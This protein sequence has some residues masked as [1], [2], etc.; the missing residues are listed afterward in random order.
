MSSGIRPMKIRKASAGSGKT[1]L[2]VQNYISLLLKQKKNNKPFPHR[3]ILAVTFTN[4]ATKEMKTRI[5]K[6]LFILSDPQKKS[7]HR[8]KLCK[9]LGYDADSLAEESKQLLLGILNDYSSFHISTIDK[10]F[11]KILRSFT[12]E[13]N[14][15]SDYSIELDTTKVLKEAI[16]TMLMKVDENKNLFDWLFLF[17]QEKIDNDKSWDIENDILKL[18]KNLFR[19]DVKAFNIPEQQSAE[20]FQKTLKDI[21][22]KFES[23]AKEIADKAKSIIENHNLEPS[24]FSGGATRSFYN[25]FSKVYKKD[26][27]CKKTFIEAKDNVDKWY[28]QT[29]KRK[30]DIK[31]VFKE[32][33]VCVTDLFNLINVTSDNFIR[34]NSAKQVLNKIYELGILSDVTKEIKNYLTEEGVLLLPDMNEFLS[35]IIANSDTPF[36]YEKTG[37]SI[38]H[39]MLDEFQ[40]TSELQW[41]NFLPLIQESLAS[42]NENLIVGDVKQS[43]YRW[44]NSDWDL[45]NSKIMNDLQPNVIDADSSELTTNWRSFKNIV[46]FNN[47]FFQFA[48]ETAKDTFLG[49]NQGICQEYSDKIEKA[50]EVLVQEVGKK[51]KEE[52][53]VELAFIEKIKEEKFT[54]SA[55]VLLAKRI[56]ELQDRGYALKDIVV[57]VRKRAEIRLIADFLSK[58]EKKKNYRYD[59]LSEEALL[60]AKSDSVQFLISAM[61]YLAS[62]DDKMCK[63][64]FFFNYF[65]F[66]KNFELG[67]AINEALNEENDCKNPIFNK[68][69][70]FQNKGSLYEQVEFLIRYF[71]FLPER[72]EEVIYVQTFQDIVFDFIKKN[73]ADLI[74]F[75][76]YWEEK[77][78]TFYLPSSEDSQDAIRIITIH[79][80]KGLEFD[81]VILPFCNWDLEPKSSGK[82]DSL[83]WLNTEN[84]AV[85]FNSYPIVPLVYKKDLTNTI[86]AKQY[87]EEM[88]QCYVDTLN[89]TYVA[90]T[91]AKKELYVFI[92]N[93]SSST[94]DSTIKSTIPSFLRKYAEDKIDL[95]E[96]KKSEE[97]ESFPYEIFRKGIFEQISDTKT[98]D[99]EQNEDVLH[100]EYPIGDI[101]W[102]KS[103]ISKKMWDVSSSSPV[104]MKIDYGVLMH[105]ILS[106]VE[107]L[108]HLSVAIDSYVSSGKITK[109]EGEELNSKVKKI[110]ETHQLEEWFS[111]KY[112][113][114]NEVDILLDKKS[115]DKKIRRPDRI[116]LLDNKAVVVDY[117]FGQIESRAYQKQIQMYCDLIRNMGYREVEGYLCYLE[118]D[119]ID[120]EV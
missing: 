57:L 101:D 48:S 46:N 66:I 10:F 95:C 19:E 39:F 109:D 100:L 69:F 119:K 47:D 107:T 104:K 118:L 83:L 34:Y 65:T 49:K 81:V 1:F 67:E 26:F 41:K 99:C 25:Q 53:N 97:N 58:Y 75:L 96:W 22:T 106:K 82:N 24:D 31:G 112:K 3:T 88:M 14:L 70:T 86:F 71:N 6:E 33:N 8:D 94:K 111:G 27:E 108:D 117:K 2:L 12:R 35:Q 20:D 50:Y 17:S 78:D 54:D 120:K 37:I 44:R 115:S 9:K 28:A 32:L 21:V 36:I 55:L 79:A 84:L 18:S 93:P 42:N 89:I 76:D 64:F 52:G 105:E 63:F 74:R 5:L 38:D 85:P 16:K 91:R 61:K 29:S 15:Q 4:K 11:L 56:E 77:R 59:I 98:E 62:P 87:Y 68:E 80:S 51:D 60:V 90:F 23:K 113:V 7:D 110:I 72:P 45:L 102:Q 114:L 30:N 40:D 116:M 92:E 13:V 103:L 73:N 43:I